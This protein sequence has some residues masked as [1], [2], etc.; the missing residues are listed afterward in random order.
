MTYV[1]LSMGSLTRSRLQTLSGGRLLF[2]AGLT[3]A[4]TVLA[5]LCIGYRLGRSP[6][7]AAVLPGGVS[8]GALSRI[9]GEP[10]G[11]ALVDRIGTLSGRLIQVEGKAA[12]L[13][14]R[15]SAMQTVESRIDADPTA[16]GRSAKLAR[17]REERQAAPLPSGGPLVP[18]GD[19]SDTDALAVGDDQLGLARLEIEVSQVA[20]T[21]E[22]LAAAAAP[23]ELETMAYPARMPIA[24]SAISSGF[25]VRV[26]PF[27]GQLARHTGIDFL[28]PINTPI[29]AAGGGRVTFAGRNAAYGNM[30]EI[31]HGHGLKTRYAH[32]SRLMVRSGDIVL[33]RQPIAI[34]GSTGRSTGTH[35]HFEVLRQGRPVEPR[36][37]L[38]REGV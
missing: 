29:R 30:V 31:D 3:F 20:Q 15:I 10:E 1:I 11:Q 7:M 34:V 35:L 25:G 13:A 19:T 22:S 16:P 6:T 9:L 24:D 38:L 12:T 21:L 4:F 2:A 17:D 8:D 14:A 27:T 5:S 18:V 28:A 23:R 37:F 32:A 33:P 26:D 36:Q